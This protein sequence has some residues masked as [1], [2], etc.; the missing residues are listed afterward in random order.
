[1]RRLPEHERD[2]LA[3]AD[4]YLLVPLLIEQRLVGIMLLGERKSEEPY[5]REDRELLRTLATQLATF[6]SKPLP[7]EP[8]TEPSGWM[9][10]WTRISPVR[11]GL[12][13]SSCS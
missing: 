9:K 13:R 5:G 2:W 4:A 12:A 6:E 7:A 3:R 10:N 8:F 1:M 11:S